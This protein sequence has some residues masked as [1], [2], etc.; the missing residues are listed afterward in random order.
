MRLG[1]AYA[2]MAP[3][4]SVCI[5]KSSVCNRPDVASSKTSPL[6]FRFDGRSQRRRRP[7][8]AHGDRFRSFQCAFSRPFGHVV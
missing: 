4:I 3:R 7:L 1:V 5:L 2:T 6:R 8:L